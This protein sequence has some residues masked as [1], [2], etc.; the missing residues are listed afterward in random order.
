MFLGFEIDNQD[1]II[2]GIHMNDHKLISKGA[3]S[4][5]KSK[6]TLTLTTQNMASIKYLTKSN[7]VDLVYSIV[8]SMKK[9]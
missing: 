8:Y 4:T 6:D 5:S 3:P 2:E 7:D 9:T 1:E